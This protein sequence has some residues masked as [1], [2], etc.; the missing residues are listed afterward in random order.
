MLERETLTL[1]VL[2]ET[3]I[4]GRT[5]LRPLTVRHLAD[6]GQRIVAHLG[7]DAEL[8][9]VTEGDAEEFAHALFAR[10]APNT[11]RRIP[12]RAKQFFAFAVKKGHVATNPFG[13]M[14]GLGVRPNRKRD[15]CVTPEDA[16]RLLAMLPTP[17]WR[18]L[19]CSGRFCGR[20]RAGGTESGTATA[21]KASH[22]AKDASG[23]HCRTPYVATLCGTMRSIAGPKDAP[24]RTRTSNH[25]IKS[26]MLC[27]LS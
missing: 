12:G 27:R 17:E 13:S 10:Y 8:S 23:P 5:D 3:H 20:L 16:R 19:F 4:T 11:V 24:W 7:A 2:I 26:Q 21:R 25:L 22:R 15:C 1:G 18:A 14:K 9:A 6:A